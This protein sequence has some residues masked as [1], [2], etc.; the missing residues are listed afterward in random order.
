[1]VG[2][3]AATIIT[4]TDP[5]DPSRQ[6]IALKT[7]SGVPV[8]ITKNVTGGT[9]GGLLDSRTQVLDPTRNA[10]GH[11]TLGL[12]DAINTQHRAGIDLSGTMGGDLF[13][14]GGVETLRS[15]TNTRQ[16]SAQ[17]H[18]LGCQRAH[19]SD[20]HLQKTATGWALTRDDTGAAVTLAG[21]AR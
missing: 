8:E 4:I 17:R 18:P 20:Y 5:Y 3:E 6:N 9:L 21:P 7:G 10:L 19:R 16:R 2:G 11:L 13:T 14:L 12:T 1:M 15:A